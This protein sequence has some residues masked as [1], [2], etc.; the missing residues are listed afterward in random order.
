MMLITWEMLISEDGLICNEHIRKIYNEDAYL[1][2]SRFYNS[3]LCRNAVQVAK[4]KT[5]QPIVW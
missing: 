4:E 5:A 1:P 3:E 2:I